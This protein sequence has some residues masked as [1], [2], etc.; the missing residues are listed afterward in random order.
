MPLK[1]KS[2]REGLELTFP[3]NTL[4][5][6]RKNLQQGKLFYRPLWQNQLAQGRGWRRTLPLP[7]RRCR[8]RPRHR[9]SA[10]G[11]RSPQ[12][13]AP[14]PT[15]RPPPRLPRLGAGAHRRGPQDSS[16][17]GLTRRSGQPPRG[18][19]AAARRG[20]SPR[21]GARAH[22][23]STR[24]LPPLTL[25]SGRGGAGNRH[26]RRGAPRPPPGGAARPRSPQAPGR[27]RPAR[28]VVGL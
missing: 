2:S 8:A 11:T 6:S 26:H 12:E 16:P 21:L 24:P 20:G 13:G 19:P 10:A 22:P 9:P 28:R 5:V 18:P 23:H 17:P 3:A 7:P 14:N 4:G 1:I 25:L 15:A 27:P